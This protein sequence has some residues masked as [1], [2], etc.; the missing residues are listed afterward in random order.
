MGKTKIFTALG[1]LTVGALIPEALNQGVKIL[2][3]ELEKRQ[4]YV[5]I[6]DVTVLPVAEASKVLDQYG[7]QHALI[8]ATASPKYSNSIDNQVIKLIPRVKSNVPATTFVKVYYVDSEVIS[9]SI[10]LANKISEMKAIRKEKNHKN[11]QK[12]VQ[13]TSKMTDKL[14]KKRHFRK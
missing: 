7:F 5:K 12:V 14:T 11:L 1:K 3:R 9:E 4:D 2:N 8:K 13:Q 10:V 6:P